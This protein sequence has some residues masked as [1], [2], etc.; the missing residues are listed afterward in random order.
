M[1]RRLT[2]TLIDAA[3]PDRSH[4]QRARSEAVLLQGRWPQLVGKKLGELS[5]VLERSARR[6]VVGTGSPLVAGELKKLESH[7]LRTVFGARQEGCWL[8]VVVGEPVTVRHEQ[9]MAPRR[10]QKPM[11]RHSDTEGAR[12][13]CEEIQDKDLRRA[14]EEFMLLSSRGVKGE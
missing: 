14:L 9:D 12:S 1:V 13:A 11:A 3:L 8:K 5:W 2:S 6:L 4:Q 7:L 10:A